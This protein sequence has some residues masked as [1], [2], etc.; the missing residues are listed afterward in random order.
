[1][2]KCFVIDNQP[3]IVKTFES[4]INKTPL[5]KLL[6]TARSYQAYADQAVQA[7][8]LLINTE[9]EPLSNEQLKLLRERSQVLIL[10]AK[11]G[12]KPVYASNLNNEHEYP[13]YLELPASYQVFLNEIGRL[14]K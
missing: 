4:Y 2:I 9:I 10:M 8:I 12:N 1:M 13:G 11:A 6:G 5:F 3:L 14:I 7:D